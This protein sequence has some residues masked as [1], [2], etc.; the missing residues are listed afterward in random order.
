M[1][2][3]FVPIE[4]FCLYA[5]EDEKWLRKLKTHLKLAGAS[6]SHYDLA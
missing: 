4:V 3:A 6:R 2:R 1:F 5:R